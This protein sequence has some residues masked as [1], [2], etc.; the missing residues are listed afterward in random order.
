MI[1]MSLKKTCVFIIL[2]V[3]FGSCDVRKEIV[4]MSPSKSLEVQMEN[5]V[6]GP[7]LKLKKND[8][9]LV[10]IDL[11]RFL[12]DNDSI[13]AKYKIESR[14][15]LTVDTTWTPVYG[16]RNKIRNHY[17]AMCLSA[18]IIGKEKEEI[19]IEL[20]VY[21]EGIAFRY[22]FDET[23][24][25]DKILNKEL[26][27]FNFYANHDIWLTEKWGKENMSQARYFKSKLS[28]MGDNLAERPLV[29]RRNDSTYLAL[30]EAAMVDYA[31]GKYAKNDTLKYGLYTRLESTIDLSKAKYKSPWRFVMV[32]DS[33]GQLLENNH[34]VLNL[35]EPNK[36]GGGLSWIKP[37]K[38]IREV[39]LT[40]KGGMAC[41]D[42]A[43]RHNI[44]YIEF[45]AGWYGHEYSDKS[46]AT[47]I[48]VDP[49]RSP[50]PLD[51]HKVIDYAN[52]KG[53]GILL[54]VNRRQLETQLNEVLLLYKS[55]GVK[56]IKYGF[57][58]NGPQEWTSW[59]HDAIRKT[60]EH[61]LM[62]GVH[63]DYRPT[64]YTRT[65]P[66]LMTVE[67]IM[68]DELSPSVEDDLN[69]LFTRM[70]AGSGDHTICYYAPRVSEKM[71]GKAA[72]MA[73][74]IMLYSPWQFLYWYDRPVGSPVKKGG[75]GESVGIID[76][77]ED[78]V[79]F[80]ALPAVWDDT[81]VIE[82]KI[83]EYAT[84]VRK[85]GD[86]W[87]LGS[88]TANSGRNIDIA[89]DF[90]DTKTKYEATIYYQNTQGLENG[91]VIIEKMEV[92]KSTRITKQIPKNSGLAIVFRKL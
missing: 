59:L 62:V 20:R 6:L 32:A 33:P 73:K 72:Q 5:T 10:K 80:D 37:G 92:E 28:E 26:T 25:N 15:L 83:G 42:F 14:E 64:G 58:Q 22:L 34:L 61:Q 86:N 39:T 23:H 76:E 2:I 35:N 82:G 41:V 87:F 74:S 16:E 66:N 13:A 85:S 53:V 21:D 79:F 27:N 77:T 49:G 68:G 9:A 88:L 65:Y 57:V 48:T 45:D 17:N 90:L 71:G 3:F 70:L 12:L 11:A 52:K 84:L 54:Y 8:N 56:G 43:V 46:D 44:E 29:L 19:K 55:W 78:L 63:D 40:T 38:V 31:R 50:G 60:A 67:G 24:F 47:T 91:K 81:K 36:I 51:L 30:G 69:T 7:I 75:A 89:L 4:I 18:S 1:Y